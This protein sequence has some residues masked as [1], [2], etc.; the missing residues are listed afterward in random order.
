MLA[1][2]A[3]QR[4]GNFLPGRVFSR[5]RQNFCHREHGEQKMKAESG[6][7]QKAQKVKPE[8]EN[9]AAR[10]G[11]QSASFFVRS[12]RNPVLIAKKPT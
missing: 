10:S 1:E 12:L 11:Y 5:E 9:P 6:K 7:R 4:K 8:T 2:P 3:G